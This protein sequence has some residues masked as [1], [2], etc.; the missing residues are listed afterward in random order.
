MFT[1]IQNRGV[2]FPLEKGSLRFSNALHFPFESLALN[3]PIPEAAK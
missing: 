3:E 2:L 1:N